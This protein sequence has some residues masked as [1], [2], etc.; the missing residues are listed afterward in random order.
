MPSLTESDPEHGAGP[1]AADPELLALPAPPQGRRL[2]SMVLMG[3]VVVAALAL[4][5]HLRPDVAYSFQGD[6]AAD[7]GSATGADLA[8]LETNRYVR[9]RGTPM[10]SRMVRFERALSGQQYAVFPLAGQRQIF[11]QV[12]LEALQDPARAAQGEFSGRLL[13]FG[14]LG[15]RFR[16]VRE[17]LGRSMGMPVTAE[18]FV[19]LAE[20]PPSAYGWALALSGLCLLIMGLAGFLLLRWFRPIPAEVP[21]TVSR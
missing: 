4:L 16:A 14:Q 11:V 17:Y 3:S 9:V 19:V 5:L 6:R 1:D 20:E 15:G 8:E 2:L 12:P 18:S 7:V 13:T 10:L 21:A